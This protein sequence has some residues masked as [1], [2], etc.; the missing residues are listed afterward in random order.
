MKCLKCGKPMDAKTQDIL[1]VYSPEKKRVRCMNCGHENIVRK[2]KPNE[3]KPK[4]K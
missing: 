4:T 1:K 2:R 3:V